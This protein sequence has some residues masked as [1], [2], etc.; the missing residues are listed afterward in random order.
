[1]GRCNAE[2][3]LIVGDRTIVDSRT[4]SQSYREQQH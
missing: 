2:V 1:V 4:D 3:P